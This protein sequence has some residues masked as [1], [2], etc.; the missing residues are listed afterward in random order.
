MCYTDPNLVGQLNLGRFR[1]IS[2]FEQGVIRHVY[3]MRSRIPGV[4]TML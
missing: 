4:D 1:F 2:C 3:M